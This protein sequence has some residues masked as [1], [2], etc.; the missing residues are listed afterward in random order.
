M[1]TDKI[2]AVVD[3]HKQAEK[4]VSELVNGGFDINHL[5]IVGKGYQ[6]EEH[7]TGFYNLSDRVKPWGKAGALWGG[8]WGS[9]SRLWHVLDPNLW[10]TVRSRATG[11]H[12]SRCD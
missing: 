12:H 2:V 1:K 10:R 6:T 9:T 11:D 3:T 7:A 8:I 4:A 5:S